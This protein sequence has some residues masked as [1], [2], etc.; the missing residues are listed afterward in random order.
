MSPRRSRLIDYG[1]ATD[2]TEFRA[3]QILTPAAHADLWEKT[4]NTANI[5][6]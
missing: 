4:L 5:S 1:P 6:S 2:D 3:F